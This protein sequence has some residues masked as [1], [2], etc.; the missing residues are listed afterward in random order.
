[1][2]NAVRGRLLPAAVVVA[3]AA[4]DQ[5]TKS[6]AVWLVDDRVVVWGP[7]SLAVSRNTG[8]P[9]GV[10]SSMPSAWLLLAVVGAVAALWALARVEHSVAVST[11]AAIVAGGVFG[12]L[13]DRLARGSGVAAGGVVDWL[14][15]A[16]YPFAFNLADVALRAG[17]VALVVALV[18]P[19][20][21]DVVER[22]ARG[23]PART[24]RSR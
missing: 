20:D 17:A 16:P 8:G 2:T 19:A 4:M 11:A 24:F 23:A 21:A 5:A 13:A 15:V 6:L 14:T 18:R 22:S 12:N 7:V 9:F 1:V 3:V 10:A